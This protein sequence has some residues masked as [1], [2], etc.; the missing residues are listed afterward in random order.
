MGADAAV[1]KADR[2]ET[3]GQEEGARAV[4]ATV[5]ESRPS[6]TYLVRLANQAQVI[7]HAAGAGTRNFV[8]IRPGDAVI[9]QLSP[10]D[11]TRGRIVRR[12]EE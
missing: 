5:I 4:R 2:M 8:R 3:A 1:S 7:A 11:H 10:H 6:A 9:V 12:L